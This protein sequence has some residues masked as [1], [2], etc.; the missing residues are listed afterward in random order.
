MKKVNKN[1]KNWNIFQ[2]EDYIILSL[3]YISMEKN[4][5]KIFSE[6]LRALM[7]E[8][9]LT[10]REIAYA[11]GC[12]ET[13]ISKWLLMKSEPTLSNICKLCEFFKCKYEELLDE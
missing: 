1:T 12:D 8:N 13:T 10:A 7:K 2:R 6:N 11:I 3:Y 4:Y 5:K 9:K